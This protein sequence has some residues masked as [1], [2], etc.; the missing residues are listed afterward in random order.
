MKNLKNMGNIDRIIRF[1]V[2]AGLLSLLFV[3][4]N[5][6]KYLGILG[7]I[8]LLTSAVGVCPLYTPFKINTLKK[9]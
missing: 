6:W 7:I 3:V 8:L 9:K 4:N 1:I 2:G 5:N